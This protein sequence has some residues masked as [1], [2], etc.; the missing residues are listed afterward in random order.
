MS[1][2]EKAGTVHV[3]TGCTHPDREKRGPVRAGEL[4]LPMIGE[5]V[6][7]AGL[8]DR[9]EVRG[10]SCIGQC[11]SRLRLSVGGPGRWSWLLGGL[12]TDALPDELGTFL[13]RWTDAPDGFL[14]KEARPLPIRRLMIG[15]V[16]PL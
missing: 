11:D 4:L 12:T 9:L 8:A 5:V 7:K 1:A 13:R 6:G 15:R 10:Y 16:P 2:N 14:P 3:C